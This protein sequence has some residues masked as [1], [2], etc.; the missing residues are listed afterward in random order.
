M[1]QEVADM[2]AYLQSISVSAEELTPA[3]AYENACGRC[4]ANHYA[5]W[6]QI[7]TK[8]AFKKTKAT[9]R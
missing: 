6:T 8:P 5:S 1:D 9:I 4:H 7:G 2:V 3:I